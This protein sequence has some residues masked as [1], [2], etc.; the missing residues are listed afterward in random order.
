MAEHA[1][2]R[3]ASIL[4]RSKLDDGQND[5]ICGHIIILIVSQAKNPSV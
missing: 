5:T 1:F 4:R 2:F 3:V